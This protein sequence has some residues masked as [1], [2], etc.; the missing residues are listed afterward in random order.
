[1]MVN[2]EVIATQGENSMKTASGSRMGVV[3]EE[4][5]GEGEAE[6]EELEDLETKTLVDAKTF[7][8]F[9]FHF[10]FDVYFH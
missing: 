7:F 1:M 10:L 9:D 8:T 6:G 2:L 5:E 3:A 4:L